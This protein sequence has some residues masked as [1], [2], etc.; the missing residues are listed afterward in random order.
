MPVIVVLCEL[1]LKLVEL[2]PVVQAVVEKALLRERI[3]VEDIEQV[4]E[5]DGA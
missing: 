2:V 3:D 1:V 5:R 4:R